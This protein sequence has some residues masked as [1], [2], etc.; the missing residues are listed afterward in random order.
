[1][2]PLLCSYPQRVLSWE[3]I[4]EVWVCPISNPGLTLLA[5]GSLVL[6]CGSSHLSDH[7]SPW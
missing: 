1:M 5:L 7:H 6:S 4:L 2:A 3:V